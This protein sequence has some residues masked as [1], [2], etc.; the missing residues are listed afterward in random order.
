MPLAYFVGLPW[1]LCAAFSCNQKPARGFLY[2]IY[3][4]AGIFG[5][6]KDKNQGFSVEKTI[7]TK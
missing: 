7:L 1:L 5:N 6:P 3:A 2:R 4:A